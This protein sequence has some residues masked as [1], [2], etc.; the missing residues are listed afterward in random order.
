MKNIAIIGGGL[1]GVCCAYYLDKFSGINSKKFNID[2]IEKD[3][4]FAKNKFGKFQYGQEI[5]DNGWHG[6]VSEQGALFYLIIELGL[7]RYLMRSSDTKKVFYTTEGI[8]YLPEKMLYGYPLD[9]SELLLSDL[10]TFKEKISILYNM[11]NTLEDENIQQLT[12]EEFFKENLNEHIYS[13]LIEPLLTSHYGSEVSLQNMVSLMPEL[14][15]LTI[16]REDISKVLQEM[17]NRKV[18]DNITIGSEYRLKFTLKSFVE[19]LESNFSDKVFLETHRKVE[20]IE[21][22][23]DRY[24]VYSNGSIYEYDYVILTLN[25]ISFLPWFDDDRKVKEFYNHLSYVSNV[26]VTFIF[27][28]EE[29]HINREIGE[30]IFPNDASNYITKL[31]YVSNKWIDI[32]MS[33]IQIVRAYIDRQEA[34]SK[35]MDKGDDEI[36]EIIESELRKVHGSVG[37][38][39]RFYVSKIKDNYRFRCKNYNKNINQFNDYMKKEYPN[40]F[41]IGKSKKGTTLENT[42]L[43]AKEVAKQILENIR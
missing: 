43:E 10:F 1:S 11:H 13:K 36:K 12:V 19:T 7:H 32:K 23:G 16:Q 39:S 28:R 37:K 9:K 3:L 26:V 21:K 40:V 22:Q 20:K 38:L 17:Y 25:H 34:V 14:S 5:Y 24:L 42:V 31:E 18:V 41:I 29:L 4:E 15:F 2:L 33:G 35:L 8:K 30:I 27:K 6:S